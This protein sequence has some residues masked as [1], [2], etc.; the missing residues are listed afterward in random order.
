M[1]S[2][3]IPYY[4]KRK[5]IERCI[6]SVLN[7]TYQD[8]QII[9]VDDGSKDD[10]SF[11]CAEKYG[12]KVQ[13]IVQ[14]NQG[15]SAARNIG[16]ANAKNDY[17][18]FLDADDFWHID[19]LLFANIIINQTDADLIAI[20][21]TNNLSKLQ[22]EK[23]EIIFNVITE[24]SYLLKAS[25]SAVL[26][27]SCVIAKKDL[28]FKTAGFDIGLTRG[29]DI[30]MWLRLV[31]H[32]KRF[33]KINNILSFYDLDVGGQA[34]ASKSNFK[35][36]FASRLEAYSKSG[37]KQKTFARRFMYSRLF[38][39]HFS[40]PDKT[41]YFIALLELD[42]PI[43]SFYRINTLHFSKFRNSYF[44]M[45]INKYLKLTVKLLK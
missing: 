33:V 16:I 7:Q 5:Y 24:D 27:S 3:V 13:L 17:I 40:N 44:R 35:S 14:E 45:L 34:T 39:Y 11:L 21:S 42:R 15:V 2:V 22:K 19:Y 38:S 36:S 9:L 37:E 6:D 10:I 1:F 30:E 29:E 23:K 8:F 4:K 26:N 25:H 32:S 18:A 28:L 20:G 41:A 31:H 43:F 12:D